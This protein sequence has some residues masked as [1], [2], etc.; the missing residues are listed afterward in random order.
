MG[1]TNDAIL[2]GGRV[3]IAVLGAEADAVKLANALPS[4]SSRDYG[5][6]FV[7]TFKSYGGDFYAIDPLLF[8]PARIAITNVKSGRTFEAGELNAGVLRQSLFG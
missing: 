1:R 7:E 8:S 2:Y 3:H 6:P 5:K 4:Q